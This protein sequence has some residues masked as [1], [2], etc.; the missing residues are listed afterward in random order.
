MTARLHTSKSYNSASKSD[1]STIM[2]FLGGGVTIGG[3][4]SK[5]KLQVL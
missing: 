5:P 4:V 3:L 1:H 2:P